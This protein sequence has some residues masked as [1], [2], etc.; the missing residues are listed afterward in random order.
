MN[1]LER[2][3]FKKQIDEAL[4]PYG[5]SAV[6]WPTHWC[7]LRIVKWDCPWECLRTPL[8]SDFI[9]DEDDWLARRG[10]IE[11]ALKEVM[12]KVDNC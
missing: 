8:F 11:A 3:Q 5:A 2:Y 4:K 1:A 12:P 7:E 10:A 6:A 9:K